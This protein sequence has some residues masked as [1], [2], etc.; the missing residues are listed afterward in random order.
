MDPFM[1]RALKLAEKGYTSPNPMVG[2][3]LVRDGEI[4][5]EGYHRK[6]GMPHAEVE[7]IEDAKRRGN[8]IE[9]STLYVTLEPC[10]HY[11]RTP[12]C[13]DAIIREGIGKVI[14]GMRDP[15]P[16]VNGKGMEKLRE[17]GIEVIEKNYKECRRINEVY[18]KYTK[19]KMPFILLKIAITLNG[20]YK[21]LDRY[22]SSQEA[23]RYAH[24]LRKRYDAVAIGANTLRDDD[25][26]LNVRLVDAEGRDPYKIVFVRDTSTLPREFKLLHDEKFVAVCQKNP[27]GINAIE[28]EDLREGMKKLADMGITSVL[29]EGGPTIAQSALNSD[30]VD[31][32]LFIV[33][34]GFADGE[35]LRLNLSIRMHSVFK[36][37]SDIA[38]EA[39]VHGHN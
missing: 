20:C 38:V 7:A 5:G 31:K 21:T 26:Q 33:A 4:I 17:A 34:P 15:N 24:E 1:Q 19:E 12:P 3:V 30:L 10:C 29:L 39:Y 6:A 13:T 23:L 37:G 22:I 36:L 25:P 18:F 28:A 32:C 35:Q 14:A 8:E 27:R 9:G 16:K 11:G 2:A